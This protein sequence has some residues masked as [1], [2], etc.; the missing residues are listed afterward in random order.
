MKS[1]TQQIVEG[2]GQLVGILLGVGLEEMSSKVPL[3]VFSTV[4][5]R[6]PFDD[7][8]SGVSPLVLMVFW[9][10]LDLCLIHHVER[11]A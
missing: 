8:L 4:F 1:R 7:V 6:V 11:Q 10:S 2:G 9:T 3:P 5:L